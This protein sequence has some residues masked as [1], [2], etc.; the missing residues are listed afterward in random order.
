MLSV[1]SGDT[2]RDCIT[3]LSPQPSGQELGPQWTSR[4][5]PSSREPLPCCRKGLTFVSV[6][7]CF[8]THAADVPIMNQVPALPHYMMDTPGPMALSMWDDGAGACDPAPQALVLAPD[9]LSPGVPGAVCSPAQ[10]THP[11]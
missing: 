4:G 5:G 1:Q 9:A 10:P 11:A 3:A 7:D 2:G 8:W 6:H